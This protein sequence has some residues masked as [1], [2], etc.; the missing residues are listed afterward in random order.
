MPFELLNSIKRF[1]TQH[2][3]SCASSENNLNIDLQI[4]DQI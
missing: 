4:M 3:Q 1:A 2:I